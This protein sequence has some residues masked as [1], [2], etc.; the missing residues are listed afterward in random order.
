LGTKKPGHLSSRAM[1]QI[2]R[3]PRL[4]FLVRFKQALECGQQRT[5]RLFCGG[6]LSHNI[7]RLF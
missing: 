4:I 5:F 3:N 6:R 2:N 1:V 7:D